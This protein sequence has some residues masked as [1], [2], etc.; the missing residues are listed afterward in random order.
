MQIN[1]LFEIIYILLNKKKITAKELSEYFE[2][3]VRTIYRDIEILSGC[4]IPIYTAKG[5]NG[6]ISIL[7]NFVFNKSLL[8][9]QE[10][11]NI[12]TSLKLLQSLQYPNINQTTNKLENLF[13][14]K[15]NDWITIDFSDWGSCEKEKRKFEDLKNAVL[16]NQVIMI[17]YSNTQGVMSQRQIE[18]LK[19]VFKSRSWYLY[20][21]CRERKDL[22][23]FKIIRIKQYEILE[24]TFFRKEEINM[25][26]EEKKFNKLE[27]ID[28]L[29]KI[30]KKMG[31]RVYDEFEPE[32]VSENED[33][34]FMIQ[35]TYPEDE[36]LYGYILSFGHFAKVCKP[37]NLRKII[38][39]RLTEAIKEYQP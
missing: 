24:E 39:N 13:C 10:Q 20:A 22:R 31:Y 19:I 29:L 30:D 12:L 9:T 32:Q 28:I 34:S 15:E 17:Q 3:S 18:P 27:K 38:L 35:I 36:W 37:L 14:N 21:Y 23:I 1:R 8:S 25:E 6:G 26:K 4:N 16:K 11:Q 2:V 5:R 33:G 7:D